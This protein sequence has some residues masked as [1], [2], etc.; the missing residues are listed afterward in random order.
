M[1]IVLFGNMKWVSVSG[2]SSIQNERAVGVRG[3][4]HHNANHIEITNKM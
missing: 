2:F 4:E 1:Q 3:S